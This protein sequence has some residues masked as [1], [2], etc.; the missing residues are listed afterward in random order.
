MKNDRN[1]ATDLDPDDVAD[2]AHVQLGGNPR[3]QP[4]REGGGPGHDMAELE[5]VLRNIIFRFTLLFMP[6]AGLRIL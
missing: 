6:S 5:L 3:Q 4:A 1:N 2:G